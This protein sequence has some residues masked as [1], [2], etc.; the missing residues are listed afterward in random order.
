MVE[1]R[2][3]VDLKI[4]L[5]TRSSTEYPLPYKGSEKI[6][7]PATSAKTLQ[8]KA[9]STDPNRNDCLISIRVSQTLIVHQVGEVI[10]CKAE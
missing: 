10:E 9:K 1:N 4:Q 6:E 8:V 5:T 7:F 2:T 3:A